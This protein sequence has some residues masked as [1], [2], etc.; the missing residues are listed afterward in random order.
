MQSIDRSS[1][2]K[3]A[4]EESPVLLGDQMTLLLAAHCLD[5]TTGSIWGLGSGR[6]VLRLAVAD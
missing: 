3:E 4:G 5:G 1:R 2:R 6:H